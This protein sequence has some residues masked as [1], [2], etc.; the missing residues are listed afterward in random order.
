MRYVIEQKLDNRGFAAALVDAAVK[1]HV[2]LV[3]DD[4]GCSSARQAE[5]RPSARRLARRRLPPPSMPMLDKLVPSGSTI[6]MDNENHATF[7]SAI[8]A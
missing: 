1:G 8:K 2:R 4:G 3:E 6:E 7:S 5:H